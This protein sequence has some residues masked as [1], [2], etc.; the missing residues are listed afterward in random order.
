MRFE[1]GLADELRPGESLFVGHFADCSIE[2]IAEPDNVRAASSACFE[3]CAACHKRMT[4]LT[5][6]HQ[7]RG[8]SIWPRRHGTG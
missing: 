5:S 7:R 6:A 4:P 3:W 2:F 1:Y 8:W